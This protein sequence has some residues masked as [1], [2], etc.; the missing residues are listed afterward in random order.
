MKNVEH[1]EDQS[2]RSNIW[3]INF[4]EKG[5]TEI[6]SELKNNSLQAEKALQLTHNECKT[7]PHL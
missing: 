5:D 1:L 2:R 3:L 6:I 7:K 4:Q